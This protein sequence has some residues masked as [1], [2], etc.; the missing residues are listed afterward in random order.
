MAYIPDDTHVNFTL[1]CKG[2][3]LIQGLVPAL[4][5]PFQFTPN[6]DFYKPT[7]HNFYQVDPSSPYVVLHTELAAALWESL[8]MKGCYILATANGWKGDS[9]SPPLPVTILPGKLDE[10]DMIHPLFPPTPQLTYNFIELLE[11]KEVI[12]Q[13]IEDWQENSRQLTAWISRAKLN[14]LD[15]PGHSWLWPAPPRPLSMVPSSNSSSNNHWIPNSSSLDTTFSEASLPPR[16]VARALHAEVERNIKKRIRDLSLI[17]E[18]RDSDKANKKQLVLWK[19]SLAR[20]LEMQQAIITDSVESENGPRA[21]ENLLPR[22]SSAF[23]HSHSQTAD[24]CITTPPPS[25]EPSLANANNHASS[26]NNPLGCCA[27]E[28]AHTSAVRSLL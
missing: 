13:R 2:K 9:N 1:Y 19:P 28:V 18:A 8:K 24:P 10:I 26:N 22:V 20:L 14:S 27:F 11:T 4:S 17:N 5:Y 25:P 3:S 7:L 23:L 6:F 15:N 21:M 12:L 16:H